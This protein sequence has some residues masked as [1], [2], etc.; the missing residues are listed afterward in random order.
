MKDLYNTT[1][2]LSETFSKSERTVKGK[3]D[4][5]SQGEARPKTR[6]KE[7]FEEPLNRPA[8]QDPPH[9]QTANDDLPY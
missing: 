2:K 3:E 6:R 1:K 8:T 4:R 9:I 7:H 5:T